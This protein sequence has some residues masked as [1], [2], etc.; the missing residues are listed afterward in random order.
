MTLGAGGLMLELLCDTTT[1]LLPGRRE[2]IEAA[3]C[4]LKRY[5]LLEGCRGRPKGDIPAAI[6]AITRIAP[7]V[8][9]PLGRVVFMDEDQ[10]VESGSCQETLC[11]PKHARTRA[12]VSA[13]MK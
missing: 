1:L 11:D 6:D 9:K 13:V 12:F 5:P 4:G 8:Q 10:I 3:W 7:F 2:G